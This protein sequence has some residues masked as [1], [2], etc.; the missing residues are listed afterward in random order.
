MVKFLDL[1]LY[2]VL[3]YNALIMLALPSDIAFISGSDGSTARFIVYLI[4][5][6]IFMRGIVKYGFKALPIPFIAMLIGW[7][8]FSSQ[9]C[10]D[11]HFDGFFTPKDPGL[12]NFKPM[13]ECL[14]FFGMM[15][16]LYSWKLSPDQEEAI[17]HALGL[18]G[19]IMS[20]YLICQHFGADQLFRLTNTMTPDH[21][22]RNPT[23][24][25][26]ILQPVY[27]SA[28]IMML[29]PFMCR[30]HWGW[31]WLASAAIGMT[32]NR[33]GMLGIALIWLYLI[34]ENRMVAFSLIGAYIASIIVI[35]A[36]Y[37]VGWINLDSFF[38]SD[39]R[40]E[41]WGAIIKDFFVPAFPGI[42]KS[43]VLTGQ[44]IGAFPV[45]FPFHNHSSFW[46][47]H[48]EY[49]EFWRGCSFIGLGLMLLSM[50]DLINKIQNKYIFISLLSIFV[51]A[52]TN[53]VWH[54]PQ[55]Q[56]LTVFLIGIG[57]NLSTCQT[58][59]DSYEVR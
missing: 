45:V 2:V 51:F 10:P 33:S 44:G 59:E 56:F 49:L 12:F 34:I 18:S 30:K 5:T 38:Y 11:I 23:S 58:R 15:M 48:N 52:F 1:T 32:A 19:I 27:A 20:I 4:A 47:A 14:L 39:G 31:A 13:F 42:D 53:P 25:S 40:L 35:T 26:F 16:S 9:H 29:M 50:R 41:A 24:G 57:L 7:I 37:T 46:Q 36:L 28:M 55:L 6:L 54:I 43:F 3:F 17:F 22:S 8:V 21:F